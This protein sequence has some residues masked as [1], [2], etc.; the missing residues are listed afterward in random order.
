MLKMLIFVILVRKF[1]SGFGNFY[2]SD[3]RKR[4]HVH[5]VKTEY[6]KEGIFNIGPVCMPIIWFL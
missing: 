4:I 2:D 6:K 3:N 5:R 1:S